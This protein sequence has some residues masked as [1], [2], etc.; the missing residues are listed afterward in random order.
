MGSRLTITTSSTRMS[1]M[2]LLF[3]LRLSPVALRRTI[4]RRSREEVQAMGRMFMRGLLESQ[5]SRES[6]CALLVGT[7]TLVFALLRELGCAL[8][9]FL[10]T[11][12]RTSI[13]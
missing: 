1:I 9:Y 8:L 11:V 5:S 3:G 13:G 12:L 4:G 6:R 7:L 10:M 2:C